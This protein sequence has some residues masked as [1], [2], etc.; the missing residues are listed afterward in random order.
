MEIRELDWY[1]DFSCIGGDCPQTCCRGWIIPLTPEDIERLQSEHGTL[2]LRIFAAAGGWTRDNFNQRSRQCPFWNREGLCE[3]QLKKGHAFIPDAC[4]SYPRFYR[5]YG[6]FEQRT[7]DLSCVQAARMFTQHA[8]QISFHSAEGEPATILCSTN[9]D[10]EFLND[11]I[12]VRDE[13]IGELVDICD[14]ANSDGNDDE[15][16][17]GSEQRSE[18]KPMDFL[19]SLDTLLA[20]MFDFA[21]DAQSASL[22]Q[23]PDFT[24]R[25]PEAPHQIDNAFF[26][27]SRVTL[28]KL[29]DSSLYHPNLAFSNPKLYELIQDAF[30]YIDSLPKHGIADTKPANEAGTSKQESVHPVRKIDHWV[31]D[32][33]SFLFRH[34]ETMQLYTGYLTY[35]LHQYF[36]RIYETYSYRRQVA[37]G[38]IHLNLLFLLDATYE[39]KH[40]SLS[41][42]EFAEILAVYNRRAYFS[43]KI[44]DELYR[45]FEDAMI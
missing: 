3:L 40:G 44:Q 16:E 42:E 20:R 32:A 25:F 23:D 26:P 5:N 36:L 39:K 35:Y 8:G 41:L 22:G 37:L 43:D 29:L 13:M 19:S 1:Q 33:E 6:I 28:R 11:L 2:G 12:K 21:R 34:P 30:H 4:Q 38:I 17:A 9:D 14:L 15:K 18:L 45:I 7:L 27:L 31:T 24:F 10:T